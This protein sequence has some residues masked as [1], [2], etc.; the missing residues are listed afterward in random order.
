MQPQQNVIVR[1]TS[2]L[3]PEITVM[4]M[5][6]VEYRSSGIHV[7]QPLFDTQ[8]RLNDKFLSDAMRA[9]IHAFVA[10]Y[11]DTIEDNPHRHTSISSDGGS[12]VVGSEFTKLQFPLVHHTEH[13]PARRMF[14]AIVTN[15]SMLDDLPEV[16]VERLLDTVVTTIESFDDPVDYVIDSADI[17]STVSTIIRMVESRLEEERKN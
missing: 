1:P 4:T 7:C 9:R 10:A 5:S 11:Y 6:G 14:Y 2:G 8:Y 13:G 12:I 17:N 15:K 3:R 16:V